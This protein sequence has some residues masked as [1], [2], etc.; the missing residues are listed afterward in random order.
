MRAIFFDVPATVCRERNRSRGRRVP[1]E[2]MNRLAGKLQ[3]PTLEEGFA[4]IT[5][6]R[7]KKEGVR[8]QKS[9]VR[10]KTAAGPL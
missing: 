8:S 5:V 1:E 3:P 4:K 9:G 6:V 2:A 7:A 10:R